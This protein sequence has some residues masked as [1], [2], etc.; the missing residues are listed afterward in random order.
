MKK[1]LQFILSLWFIDCNYGQVWGQIDIKLLLDKKWYFE[2]MELAGQIGQFATQKPC[3]TNSS[4]LFRENIMILED[5]C[6]WQDGEYRWEWNADKSG[7]SIYF[8]DNKISYKILEM[9]KN[10]LKIQL[11]SNYPIIFLLE[12]DDSEEKPY[13]KPK[14]TNAI[15]KFFI[16]QDESFMLT[17]STD[18]IVRYWDL[19]NNK[20]LKKM[21]FP[22]EVI[23]CTDMRGKYVAIGTEKGTIHI[24][25]ISFGFDK[26]I[27]L[28]Q[29]QKNKITQMRIAGN[30]QNIFSSSLDQT[31][32]F[33]DITTGKMLSKIEN[34]D[35]EISDFIAYNDNVKQKYVI[36][37]ATNNFIH[38]YDLNSTE[39]IGVSDIHNSLINCLSYSDD[40]GF[41]YLISGD[42]NGKV[43][44]RLPLGTPYEINLKSPVKHLELGNTSL[45]VVAE[46][47]YMYVLD[48]F[49]IRLDQKVDIIDIP[50]CTKLIWN[51]EKSQIYISGQDKDK[52][53]IVLYGCDFDMM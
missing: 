10:S 12:S 45:I 24:Y 53:V 25:D 36:S 13:E 14:L 21:Q 44:M 20:V 41:G 4:Y 11:L 15:T 29:N 38:H 27:A 48:G 5:R 28:I 50:L 6:E 23:T 19:K 33:C 16:S 17:Q 30:G 18:N 32:I 52:P 9:T 42:I 26:E 51:T 3:M 39:K 49:G 2:E 43:I 7:F 31:V 22:D 40:G 35:G 47:L 37:I 46:K 34:I 1:I 8:P